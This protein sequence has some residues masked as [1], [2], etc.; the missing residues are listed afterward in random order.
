MSLQPLPSQCPSQSPSP[1]AAR[2]PRP[3]GARLSR[4]ALALAAAGCLVLAGCARESEAELIASAKVF[5]DKQ[6]HKA[7]VIQLKNALQKNNDAVEARVLLGQ[8]LLKLGDGTGAAVELGKA[9]DLGADPDRVL[10]DLARAW[11]LIGQDVRVIDQLSSVQLGAALPRAELATQLA[12]AHMVQGRLDASRAA[13]DTALQ[14]VPTHAPALT[15]RAR[16]LASAGDLQAA[17]ALVDE[18]LQRAPGQLDAGM[19]KSELQLA[20]QEHAGA[21]AT[22]QAVAAANPASVTAQSALIAT[23]LAMGLKDPARQGLEKLRALAPGHP[24]LLYFDAQ[25]AYEAADLPRARGLVD[26]VLKMVPDSVRALELAGA[27][28]YRRADYAQADLFL[29]RAVRLAPGRELARHMLAQTQLRLGGPER[30]L[31]VLK[32]LLEAPQVSAGTLA[33]AGEAYLLGGDSLRS[34]QAFAAAARLAP[35]DARL[36]TS[37]AM[38][39]LSR[40]GGNEQAMQSLEKLAREDDNPRA[41][42]ALVSARMQKGDYEGAMKAVEGLRRKQADR[43]LPD[44]LSGLIAQQQGQAAAARAHY[45]AALKKEARFLPAAARLATLEMAEGKPDAA[46]R[47]L[48]AQ[49]KADPN[50][51]TTHLALAEFASRN[52]AGG[53]EVTQLLRAA[54]KANPNEPRAQVALVTHLVAIGEQR[55]GLQAAQSAAAA[56]PA[57]P[58]V[59]DAL[60]L[61]QQANGDVQQAMATWRNLSTQQPRLVQPHLRLAELQAGQKRWSDAE[62][63]LQRALELE[64]NLVVAERA[65]V[66]LALQRGQPEAGLPVARAIQQRQP[67]AALG[68]MLEGDV[69]AARGK[70]DAAVSAY[71]AAIQREQATEAATR[72]HQAL[73]ASGKPQEAEAFSRQWQQGQ[74]RDAMFRFYLGDLALARTDWPAAEAHYRKVLELAPDN[75]LAMNNVAWLLATQGKPGAVDLARRANELSPGR[76]ALLDTLAMAL[77]A[78]GK[79]NEA[80]QAQRQA[81]AQ[82]P[83][84]NGLKLTLARLQLQSG[85]KASARAQLEELSKLGTAFPKQA[86]VRELMQQAR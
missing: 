20:Q 11:L 51:A 6:D 18:V 23:E 64:P 24:D 1:V 78:D 22:L 68:W 46:R 40:P 72:L 37:L 7:A 10:P 56:L 48:E 70:L 19:F 86:E 47:W 21:R 83:T 26:Q 45:E 79:F 50:N 61:A 17:A 60:G 12:I 73:L 80:V 71:R 13:I 36:R 39:Q 63:S 55:A 67:R 14:A 4:L 2:P 42:L 3:A 31:D 81:V 57:D 66:R 49:T 41:D 65:L 58:Q 54:V 27:I 85:D 76:P 32:P 59:L 74:P 84:D 75:A 34:E 30:A 8:V 29:T 15:L 28:E 82:A 44:Y 33:L 35:D 16:M 62:R 38:S 9:R 77:A 25:F 53:A 52:G 5:I 69:E 43:A